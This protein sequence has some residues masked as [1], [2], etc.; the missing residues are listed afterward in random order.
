MP[1][2]VHKYTHVYQHKT[3]HWYT[4]VYRYKITY[5]YTHVHQQEHALSLV[6]II[7]RVYFGGSQLSE[8]EL[9]SRTELA[10]V[11]DHARMRCTNEYQQEQKNTLAHDQGK[12]NKIIVYLTNLQPRLLNLV[13]YLCPMVE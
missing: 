12:E 6:Y 4:H 7:I 1:A 13:L 3:V 10:C 2:F 11:Q 8:L 5:K 9:C